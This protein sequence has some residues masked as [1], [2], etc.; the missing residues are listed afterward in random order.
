MID[1]QNTHAQNHGEAYFL[2]PVHLQL[3][4]H[5]SWIDSEEEVDKGGKSYIR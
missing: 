2:L 1:I 3:P 4:Q 5:G